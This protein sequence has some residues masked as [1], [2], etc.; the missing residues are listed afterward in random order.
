[1]ATVTK[2]SVRYVM[3]RWN[4]RIGAS[5]GLPCAAWACRRCASSR[6]QPPRT[7]AASV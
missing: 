3:D 7:A 6:N 2:S 1:M 4:K 5:R